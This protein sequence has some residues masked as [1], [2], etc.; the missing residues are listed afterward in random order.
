MECLVWGPLLLDL[1]AND[2]IDTTDDDHEYRPPHES[3]GIRTFAA[4]SKSSARGFGI[5]EMPADHHPRQIIYES[6]LERK[7]LL[8]LCAKSGIWNVHDQP[9]RISYEGLT[10]KLETHIPDYLAP[11]SY[12]HLTLPTTPY[13]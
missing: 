2:M 9:G 11:V 12:T 1:P 6:H 8:M 7:T 4:R 3:S 10:G 5:F 13:V